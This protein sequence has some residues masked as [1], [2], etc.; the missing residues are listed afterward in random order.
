MN[1]LALES[2]ADFWGVALAAIENDVN[3]NDI[4]SQVQALALTIE[5]EPRALA[6]ELFS[7]VQSTLEMAQLGLESVD[8]LAIGIGPGSWTGLRI[9]LTAWK[10]LAL[11]R[12]LPLVAVPSFDPLARAVRHAQRAANAAATLL[13]AVAPSRPDEF[14]GKIFRCDE[15]QLSVA[16]N[17]RIASPQQWAELLWEQQQVQSLVAPP[18]LTGGVAG[19]VAAILQ[20]QQREY[21]IA[22]PCREQVLLEL[23]IAGAQAIAERREADPMAVAPLYLAPS[24]AER[25]LALNSGH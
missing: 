18:I 10:T 14:Y 17:E 19:Q 8:A 6:R 16:C 5:N 21:S 13:L 24:N 15:T 22:A 7:R 3:A 12:R 1:I 20:A 4:D 23:A 25:N 2:G 11:A 9:G